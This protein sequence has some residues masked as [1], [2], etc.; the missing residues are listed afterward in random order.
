MSL[1]RVLVREFYSATKVQVLSY[2]S[3][4]IL[5]NTLIFFRLMFNGFFLVDMTISFI[6]KQEFTTGIS[7]KNAAR[8]KT[9]QE[10]VLSRCKQIG[11]RRE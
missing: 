4:Q 3:N 9:L 2:L 7:K 5:R 6:S 8:G 11:N 1:N 10:S